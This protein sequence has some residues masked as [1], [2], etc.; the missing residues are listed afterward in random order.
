MTTVALSAAKPVDDDLGWRDA[1][2]SVSVAPSR[3]NRVAG[4]RHSALD[5]TIEEVRD[6]LTEQVRLLS[7]AP[8][9]ENKALVT[10]C[11]HA[12]LMLVRQ[13]SLRY[14]RP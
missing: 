5:R 14:G 2:R 7:T 9:F 11:A 13:L 12:A 4:G 3:D 6:C 1:E 8:D 10:N